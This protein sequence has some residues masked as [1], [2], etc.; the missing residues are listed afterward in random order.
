[1]WVKLKGFNA[2][3]AVKDLE[4]GGTVRAACVEALG[5][6]ETDLLFCSLTKDGQTL[7]IELSPEKMDKALGVSAWGDSNQPLTPPRIGLRGAES[8]SDPLAALA[9][10]KLRNVVVT[11]EFAGSGSLDEADFHSVTLTPYLLGDHQDEGESEGGGDASGDG[12]SGPVGPSLSER[13]NPDPFH[14]CL[15]P[16]W[17]LRLGRMAGE[18][19]SC[20]HLNPEGVVTSLHLAFLRGDRS[21]EVE[22]TGQVQHPQLL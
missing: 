16:H 8:E 18:C 4:A 21:L 13:T 5:L 3:P 17:G 6:E 1:M 19:T 15:A 12:T 20:R 14:R 11:A 7:L 9:F 2:D 22:V 10:D